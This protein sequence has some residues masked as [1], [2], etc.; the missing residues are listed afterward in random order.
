MEALRFSNP[1][2]VEQSVA[3]HLHPNRLTQSPSLPGK[4]ERFTASMFQ[5]IYKSL[6]LA[7]RALNVTSM[8]MAYQ[9]ELL[10]ELD[11]QLD[12]GNP[13]PTV[14]EEICNITDLNLRT[15]HGAVQSCG[16]T[17]ALSVV[18]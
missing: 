18:G 1:P 12:A 4:M 13:N 9:A 10:E 6:V 11:T 3:H 7:A 16:R 15:S 8:L 17:V 2:T 5:K 14:W